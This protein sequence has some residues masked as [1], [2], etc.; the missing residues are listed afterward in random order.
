MDPVIHALRRHFGYTQLRPGQREAV[1]TA[2][3]GRDLLVVMPT[4]GGKSLCYQLPALVRPGL[5]LVISPLIA[6]M[7]D[8]VAALK[9]LGVPAAL[10]NSTLSSAEIDARLRRAIDGDL[11][12]VYVAPERFDSASF[13]DAVRRMSVGMVAI[14]EAHCVAEW[15][16]DFRPS[17]LRLRERWPALGNPPLMALTATATPEVRKAILT[18]LG[19][20]RP[21][22]IVRGFDRPN[23]YFA[24]RREEKL[25]E[26][27]QALLELLRDP[28]PGS[29]VVYASTRKMVESAAEFLRGFGIS[30]VA[31]HGG[32]DQA[33]RLEAQERWTTGEVPVVVATNA[34]G[35]GIDKEDVRS[36]IHFQMPGSLEAYYQEAGRAGRDG[37]GAVCVLLHSYRD[38]FTHEF[39]A[40]TAYPPREIVSAVYRALIEEV[41]R[42]GKAIRPKRFATRV[43]GAKSDREVESALRFLKEQGAILGSSDRG[44]CTVRW[45]AA[46]SSIDELLS[47]GEASSLSLEALNAL[48]ALVD[49]AAGRVMRLPRSELALLGGGD[50][51]RAR[52]ALDELQRAGLIGWRDHGR[53]LAY[54]PVDPDADIDDLDVDWDRLARRLGFELEKLRRM[55]EY[56]FRKGC[57]RRYLLRYFGETPGRGRCNGC[58]RCMPRDARLGARP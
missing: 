3:S 47:D 16:H 28:A 21:R 52:A 9:R 58:D 11:K 14:D 24:V 20:R 50:G 33:V 18:E 48:A 23:L 37:E 31:Y 51:T 40:H 29:H 8:Q 42:A 57:R 32:M 34:F 36:V 19:L 6:L 4:G 54:R 7:Q 27:S 5:T 1:A 22:V 30:A 53:Q 55:E 41:A 12:L 38:R 46:R 56:A 2:L 15:G 49:V 45:V 43:K 17:Y 26:K 13:R 39:F 35:M 44:G 25:E 10:V